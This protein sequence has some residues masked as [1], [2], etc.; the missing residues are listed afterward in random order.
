MR[1]APSQAS[2]LAENLDSRYAALHTAKEDAFWTARMGLAEDAAAAQ[3]ELDRLDIELNAFLQ[4]PTRL[5]EVRSALA[6]ASDP[7]VRTRLEG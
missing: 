5:S 2:T 3:R 1:S 7:I 6:A 4:D